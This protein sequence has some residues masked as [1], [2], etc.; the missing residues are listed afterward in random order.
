MKRMTHVGDNRPTII[1]VVT[2]LIF[3]TSGVC[4][5]I[6]YQEIKEFKTETGSELMTSQIEIVFFT[7]CGIAHVPIGLWVYRN[8]KNDASPY[9]IA[10]TGSLVVVL[11]YI[12]Y[13]TIAPSMNDPHEDFG[14]LNILS[15]ILQVSIIIA[16]SYGLYSI[17]IW[18]KK[19]LE[20]LR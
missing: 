19:T 3:Y 6:V 10:V 4:F 2:V 5:A 13:K 8:R 7:V 14:V 20:S 1:Y 15:R 12:M 11:L 17:I 9:L 16:A 18:K